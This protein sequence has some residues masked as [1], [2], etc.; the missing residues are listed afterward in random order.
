MVLGINSNISNNIEQNIFSSEVFQK[1][2]PAENMQDSLISFADEDSAIISSQAKLHYE[3]EK[4]NSG[5]D[6]LVDLID[7]CVISKY[8]IAAE[9]NVINTKKNMIDE[10][11]EIGD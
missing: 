4:F 11:L 2:F 3:L 1:K 5:G 9:I 7:T 6:N 8:T 10:V